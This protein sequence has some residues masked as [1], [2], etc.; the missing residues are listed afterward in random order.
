MI[1]TM[2]TEIRSDALINWVIRSWGRLAHLVICY[3]DFEAFINKTK[4]IDENLKIGI[5]ITTNVVLVTL[6]IKSLYNNIS[7]HG[8]I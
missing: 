3:K 5:I 8:R 1:E 7:N 6:D 4:K 2:I